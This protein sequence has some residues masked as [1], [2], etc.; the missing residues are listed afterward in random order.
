MD[1]I[2]SGMNDAELMAKHDLS[3][4]SLQSLFKQ[5]V[6]AGHLDASRLRKRTIMEGGDAGEESGPSQSQVPAGA[7][8]PGG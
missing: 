5:L 2:R 4:R 1:D 3:P 8:L 7:V 6:E